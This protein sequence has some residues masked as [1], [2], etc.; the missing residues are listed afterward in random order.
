MYFSQQP[1]AQPSSSLITLRRLTNNI[2]TK[3]TT[4]HALKHNTDS[5]DLTNLTQLEGFP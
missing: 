3:T 4:Q 1:V 2:G 5:G